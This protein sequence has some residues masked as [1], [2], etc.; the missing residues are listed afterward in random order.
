M[1]NHQPPRPWEVI[2]NPNRDQWDIRD[3]IRDEADRPIQD[4]QHGTLEPESNA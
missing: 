1:L 2:V 3:S 4:E